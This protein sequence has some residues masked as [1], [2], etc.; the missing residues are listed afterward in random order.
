M[1]HIEIISEKET[2][3]ASKSIK[4]CMKL[5]DPE[6]TLKTFEDTKKKGLKDDENATED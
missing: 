2:W 3:V 4:V 1:A 5:E 6:A